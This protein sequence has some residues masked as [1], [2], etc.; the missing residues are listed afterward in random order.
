MPVFNDLRA[1]PEL[2]DRFQFWFYF[3][4]TGDPYLATAA[5]LRDD[6]E[7]TCGPTSTPITRTTA[8]GNMVLVGHSMGG[9]ISKLLTV[10]SGDDFWRAGERPA[11]RR[12]DAQ[13][14]TRSELQRDLLSSSASRACAG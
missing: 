2:R 4:P 5:D 3:Y 14:E 13:P 10:D 1:D 12:P 9:L 7:R 11:V 8:L 6:L